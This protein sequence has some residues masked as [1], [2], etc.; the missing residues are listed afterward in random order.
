MEYKIPL[1]EIVHLN[2]DAVL[3]ETTTDTNGYVS[4]SDPGPHGP[5]TNETIF[6]EEDITKPSKGLWD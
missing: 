6:D 2:T 5:L 4:G 1:T 3:E